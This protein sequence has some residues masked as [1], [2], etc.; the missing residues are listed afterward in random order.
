MRVSFKEVTY[1]ESLESANISILDFLVH[2]TLT[3]LPFH[4]TVSFAV[5]Y[6]TPFRN[7][8]PSYHY[9]PIIKHT[10]RAVTYRGS[11][12]VGGDDG[13]GDGA[14]V[15]AVGGGHRVVSLVALRLQNNESLDEEQLEEVGV[16]SE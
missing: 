10:E 3:A 14:I 11:H 9:Q 15:V 4:M 6:C 2:L 8:G 7:R 16:R 12:I 5:K 13:C 1:S